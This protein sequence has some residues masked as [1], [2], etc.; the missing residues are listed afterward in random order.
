MSHF[1]KGLVEPIGIIGMGLSGVAS[2]NLISIISPD[3]K[4]FTFDSKPGVAQW[5]DLDQMLSDHKFNTLIVSPG[6]PLSTPALVK[7]KKQGARITSEL[8]I[9]F[10]CFTIEKVVAI[11]GAIGK[12]TAT[13]LLAQALQTFDANCLAVGNIGKP[14]AEYVVEVLSG[15]R[16]RA[17]WLSLELSS[18]QLENFEN[19]SADHSIIT[20][21]TANHLERYKDLAEYYET[22]WSLVK[23]TKGI[24]V[25]NSDSPDLIALAK[26]KKNSQLIFSSAKDANLKNLDLSKAQL[27]G[28]HNQQNLALV[29]TLIQKAGWPS[30]CFDAIKKYSGLR[31]RLENIGTYKG[32]RFVNDSK[33]TALDSVVS[34]VDSVIQDIPLNSSLV[35]L[36]GG[37]DKNLPWSTLSKF[38]KF[39][40]L[41]IYYFGE[42][43]EKAK[44]GTGVDGPI[45]QNLGSALD[46]VFLKLQNGDILLLSPGGTSHDEFKNFEERGDFFRKKV[47]TQFS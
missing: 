17:T 26:T 45:F 35:L 19:L 31:H 47:L 8:D 33:A 22:K 34:A 30:S 9:A 6:V 4:I 20:F 36:L 40:A 5:N 42:T 11:T 37:K 46:Q 41:K 39:D 10:S 32:I 38:K 14:L 24:V 2:L 29:A 44:I 43:A 1:I 3:K 25:I 21:L 15:K 16:Q 13:T 12:S 23:K 27:L 18:F 28:A 7:A